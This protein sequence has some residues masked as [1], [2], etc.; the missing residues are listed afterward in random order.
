MKLPPEEVERTL[1][2][3]RFNGNEF[4]DAP[5]LTITI[6]DTV[7]YRLADGSYDSDREKLLQEL[8]P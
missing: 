3:A 5:I 1:A 4:P 6:A 8:D 7:Y 2:M